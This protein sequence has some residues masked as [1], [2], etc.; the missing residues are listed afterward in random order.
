MTAILEGTA[1][2]SLAEVQMQAGQPELQMK[3]GAFRGWQR[4]GWGGQGLFTSKHSER[5]VL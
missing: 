2:I 5:G 1:P 3:A 4:E